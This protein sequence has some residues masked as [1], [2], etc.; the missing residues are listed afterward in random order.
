MLCGYFFKSDL[1]RREETNEIC[2]HRHFSAMQTEGGSWVRAQ[3]TMEKEFYSSFRLVR[4]AV[5]QA[6]VADDFP[7]IDDDIHDAH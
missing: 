6:T 3:Y 1:V 7:T 4:K 5:T 2:T